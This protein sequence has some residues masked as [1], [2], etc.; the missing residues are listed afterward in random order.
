VN[1]IRLLL[2][3]NGKR[4]CKLTPEYARHTHDAIFAELL[5]EAVGYMAENFEGSAE[6]S[7]AALVE[8]F[9]EWRGRAERALGR[10]SAASL[11]AHADP[12][13]PAASSDPPPADS[14]SF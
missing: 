12:S 2:A 9:S 1:S 6:V 5:R 14:S 4:V 3:L 11:S 7:G 8:W 10:R 13:P